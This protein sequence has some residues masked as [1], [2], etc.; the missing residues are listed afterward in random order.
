MR[1][2]IRY[3]RLNWKSIAAA[4]AIALLVFSSAGCKKKQTAAS[5][6][7]DANAKIASLSTSG[8]NS[9][10]G[11]SGSAAWAARRAASDKN[12]SVGQG[13]SFAHITYKPEVK[14]IDESAIEASLRGISSDG[15]GALFK[16][17]SAEIKALKAGDILLVKNACAAKILA[18]QT[19]GDQTVLIID[20]AKLTDVVASGEIKVDSPIGF[21][22]PANASISQ[23]SPHHSKLMDMI[24]PPVYA[25]DG[26]IDA[27]PQHNV[28]IMAKDALISGWKIDNYSITSGEN[29]AAFAARIMKDTSGFKS[30]I[31]VDGNISNFQ[32][33]SDLNFSP[34]TGQQI[35]NGVGGMSG[36]MHVV[37]QIGKD[38]PGVWAQEDKLKLPIGAKIP[39]APVLDGLPL[40]IELSAAFLIH[41]A[42]TGGNEYS[43]GAFTIQWVGSK[44]SA[45]QFA[46]PGSEGLTFTINDNQSIS[47]VAPTAMVISLCA[48]RI[49]LELSFLGSWGAFGYT[50]DYFL[51]AGAA[52]ID[53]AMDAIEKHLLPQSMYAALKA[54]PLGSLT[55]TNIL[56]SNADIY[57]QVINT[58]GVTHAP[59]VT[60]APCTKT[61]LKITAQS[62]GDA[63]LL[64]LTGNA[65]TVKDLFTKEFTQWDPGSAFCKSV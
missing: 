37:W 36:M 20:K 13:N 15:H 44:S 61:L 48:P 62:G 38:T 10:G 26:I 42:L 32:F 65:K 25:Q 3:D 2:P 43:Q 17:A 33:V 12:I 49:E 52:G 22:G 63:N 41:P 55:A 45:A 57:V 39:L 30:A 35:I 14:L 5:A 4:A 54:S 7:A 1:I 24:V 51:N 18:A 50:A 29:Q 8:S 60:V 27:N 58:E 16:N 53:L 46:K 9:F 40:E 23:P 34:S 28:T 47:A 56:N 11:A 19:D 59:N 21:H 31:S 64:G 6:N